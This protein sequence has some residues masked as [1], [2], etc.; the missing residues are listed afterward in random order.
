MKKIL[1]NKITL[2]SSLMLAVIVLMFSIFMFTRPISYEKS[3]SYAGEF[4]YQIDGEQFLEN[5]EIS[6]VFHKDNKVTTTNSNFEGSFD[7]YYFYKDG[8]V[9]LCDAETEEEYLREI[10]KFEMNWDIVVNDPLRTFEVNSFSLT[11]IAED[12]D[13]SQTCDSMVTFAIVTGIIESLFI[14]LSVTSFIFY[15]RSK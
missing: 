15:K 14:G 13:Y 8:Y 5:F 12:I 9:I 10:E 6:M 2:F 7:Q 3:Y 4:A 1:S 11:S